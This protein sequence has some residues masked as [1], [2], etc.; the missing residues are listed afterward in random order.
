MEDL[1]RRAK[2]WQNGI[3]GRVWFS[4]RGTI[5]L[6]AFSFRRRV[7]IGFPGEAAVVERGAGLNEA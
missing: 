5:R 7:G 2:H 1:T 6:R 4:P 3:I